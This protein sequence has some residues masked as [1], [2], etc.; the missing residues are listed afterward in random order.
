VSREALPV[1]LGLQVTLTFHVVLVHLIG[2]V[3]AVLASRT[4]HV[5]LLVVLIVSALTVISLGV[6]LVELVVYPPHQLDV[7]VISG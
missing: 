3:G 2:T 4:G 6:A 5:L 7:G 1:A